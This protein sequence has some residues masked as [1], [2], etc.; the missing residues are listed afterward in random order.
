[1]EVIDYIGLISAILGIIAFLAWLYEKLKPTR[2]ISWKET[3]KSSKRIAEKMIAENYLPTV[4]IG[5]GRGG[6]IMGSLVSGALGHCSLVVIDRKYEWTP[7]GR[8]EEI[9]FLT[10]IPK[11]LVERVLLIAGEAHSGKTM[12][13]YYDYLVGIGAK[14]IKK[15]V[16][17][18]EEGCTENIDYYGI[19]SSKKNIRLPWM[20]SK[21]YVRADRGPL[22]N[23]IKI[24]NNQRRINLLLVRHAQTNAGEDIFVGNCDADLT[25]DGIEKTIELGRTLQDYNIDAIYTSPLGRSE[26]TAKILNGFLMVE[27][28]VDDR[29]REID[30]GI[31]DGVS[32]NEIRKKYSKEYQNWEENYETIVP[33]NGEPPQKV[34]A[35]LLDFLEDVVAKYKSEE[36]VSI[37][38]VSHKTAI[39]ILISYLRQ[40]NLKNYRDMKI[41]NTTINKI[42][43][44][45][46]KWKVD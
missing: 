12:R 42:Y 21:N 4:I 10:Q 43:Y 11:S 28:N 7:R 1:M 32:R 13:L 37:V 36:D 2:N 6:A 15:S 29:I 31:W 40:G 46:G 25:L 20:F 17:F 3:E 19:K 9:L 41:T 44:D 35:R 23:E 38:V 39:R 22:N 34:L 27:F 24:V 5:I 45:E 30:Y 14:Q 26:K 18:L 8:K 33:K 16:L